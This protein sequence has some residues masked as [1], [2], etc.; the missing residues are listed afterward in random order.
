VS[1][2]TTK[3][4]IGDKVYYAAVAQKDFQAPCPDCLGTR[5][6]KAMTPAGS[7]LEMNCIRC[8]AYYQPPAPLRLGYTKYVGQPQTL[9]IGSVKLDTDEDEPRYMCHE[10]GVGS[11]RI[12]KESELFLDYESAL[13][14]ANI[15]ASIR[16]DQPG[17][18]NDFWTGVV[19][20]SSIEFGQFLKKA[21][22]KG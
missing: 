20:A 2:F 18:F 12:Y 15:E 5:K 13:D 6:W 10:T 19:E 7:T 16:N 1:S 4:S 14:Y 21:P 17:P 9:T 3:Y 11:G 8:A 22:K